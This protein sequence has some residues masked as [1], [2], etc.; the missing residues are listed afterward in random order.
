MSY[1]CVYLLSTFS[2]FRIWEKV[3]DKWHYWLVAFFFP[4]W[5]LLTINRIS[6]NKYFARWSLKFKLETDNEYY[7]GFS[8]AIH[9]PQFFFPSFLDASMPRMASL[10]DVLF[11]CLYEKIPL[12]PCVKPRCHPS[13]ALATRNLEKG[14]GC[15]DIMGWGREGSDEEVGINFFFLR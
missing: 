11:S 12:L 13:W 6:R 2:I 8:F 14:L 7:I 15:R 3:E 4:N 1:Y 9:F 10:C 5:L